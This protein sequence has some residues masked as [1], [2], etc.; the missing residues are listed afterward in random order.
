M[1]IYKTVFDNELEGKVWL[2]REGVWKEV[3]EEGVTTMQYTN[4]TQSVVNIGKIIEIKPTCD[5]DGNLI[6]PAV[7][8]PG[9]AYDIMTTDVIDFGQYQVFPGDKSASQFY[10]WPRN[11]DNLVPDPPVNNEEE[12]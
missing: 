7:Y 8:Y 10:G 9:W 11:T 5:S 1:Y 3:T 6:T 2:E 12:E 4:G